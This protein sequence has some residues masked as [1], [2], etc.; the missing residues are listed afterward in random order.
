MMQHSLGVHEKCQIQEINV[1]EEAVH[2][3][4]RRTRRIRRMAQ[5]NDSRIWL[6]AEAEDK[7][8]RLLCWD[9]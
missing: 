9:Q 2:T 4:G 1:Y 3:H 7:Q 5:C 8:W 6:T